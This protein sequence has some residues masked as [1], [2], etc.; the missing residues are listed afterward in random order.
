MDKKIPDT[1]RKGIGMIIGWM[2]LV[3]TPFL[4]PVGYIALWIIK[5]NGTIEEEWEAYKEVISDSIYGRI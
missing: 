4:F 2:A 5:A 3:L 1:I